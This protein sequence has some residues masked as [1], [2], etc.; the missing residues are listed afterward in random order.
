MTDKNKLRREGI[1]HV[2]AVVGAPFAI[3]LATSRAIEFGSRAV[4]RL[5]RAS[6]ILARRLPAQLYRVVV[7]R[8]LVERQ[9]VAFAPR[10]SFMLALE[11][12]VRRRTSI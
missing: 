10:R 7:E 3:D 12:I 6:A 1:A 5:G 2:L 4:E 11:W 8:Q 9:L